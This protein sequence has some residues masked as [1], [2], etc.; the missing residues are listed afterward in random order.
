MSDLVITS[1]RLFLETLETIRK[2]V[3]GVKFVVSNKGTG[4][5]FKTTISRIVANTNSCKTETPDDV[6]EFSLDDIQKLVAVI[7]TITQKENTP[8]INFKFNGSTLIFNET[9]IKLKLLTSKEEIIATYIDKPI[10]TTLVP[11]CSFDIKAKTVG[12]ILSLVS[13][14]FNN[15]VLKFQIMQDETKPNMIYVKIKASE[16]SM[17]NEIYLHIAN[18]LDGGAFENKVIIDAERLGFAR[19]FGTDEV[20]FSV[21]NNNV[22]LLEANKEFGGATSNFTLLTSLLKSD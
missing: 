8:Q 9:L 19:Y 6:C 13:S 4:I 10:T 2:F 1:P 17:T 5:H 7:S 22:L 11:I 16:S 20:R 3:P 14:L 18:V 15:S 12:E 21:T